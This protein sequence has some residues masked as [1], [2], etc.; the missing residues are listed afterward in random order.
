MSFAYSIPPVKG[1]LH[2][3]EHFYQ[4]FLEQ[5]V[6]TYKK[7]NVKLTVITNKRNQM[8]NIR[9]LIETD[10]DVVNLGGLHEKIYFWR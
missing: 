5:N 7:R 1:I 6:L 2:Y 4:L 8:K 9:L 3:F 10:H